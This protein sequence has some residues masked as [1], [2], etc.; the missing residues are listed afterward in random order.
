M[1][2]CGLIDQA[3]NRKSDIRPA[4]TAIGRDG[5]LVG[6]QQCRLHIQRRYFIGTTHCYRQIVGTDKPT[7]V[8]IV[9]TQINGV[10]KAERDNIIITVQRY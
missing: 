7:E 10:V 8:A 5:H 3:L 2:R 9:G 6:V 1:L 4:G